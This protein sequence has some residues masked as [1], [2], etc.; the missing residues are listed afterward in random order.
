MK[1]AFSRRHEKIF[2]GIQE[3]LFHG[4][5]KS[6]FFRY[7]KIRFLGR[8]EKAIFLFPK[9]SFFSAPRKPIFSVSEKPL[10]QGA[11]KNR[12]LSEP[13]KSLFQG[14]T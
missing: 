5:M 6:P 2:F 14:A 4:A 1:I 7:P 10:L 3:S 13:E 11:M 12:F 9:N 8:H